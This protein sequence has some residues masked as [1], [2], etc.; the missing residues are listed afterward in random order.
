MCAPGGPGGWPGPGAGVPAGPATR[1]GSGFPPGGPGGPGREPAA[2]PRARPGPA[3][4]PRERVIIAIDLG[5]SGPKVALVRSDGRLLGWEF[6]PV[7]TFLGEGGAAEQRPDDWFGA[8]RT[9]LARLLGRRIVSV[10]TITAVSVTAQWMGTVAIDQQGEPV[11]NAVIWMDSRGAPYAGR[12][13]GGFPEVPGTGYNAFKLR[14][15]LR[16]SGGVPSRTGKDPV[17][18][19]LWLQ[20]ERPD[21]FAAA[22]TF[23]DVPD[24]VNFR[25]TGRAC[26][27]FDT[28]VGLWATDNRDLSQVTYQDEL[29]EMSGLDR[30]RLPEL[31]PT[32][33]V[34]GYLTPTAA[35]ELG[36]G[37]H[38]RHVQVVTATGDTSSAAIG[39]GAVADYDAHLYIGTSSWL[40]CHVPFK[41]T[42]V[43][44]NVTS[45]PSGIPG[46]WWV[47]TEQDTAA[48]AL[49][50]AIDALGLG[51]NGVDPFQELF[52]LAATAP[53]GSGGVVFAPWLNGE[54]TPVDDHNLRGVWF[55][56]DLRTSRAHLARAVL[57][58]VAL[59]TR[60]MLDA[61]ERFVHRARPQGFE[62]LTLVGGGARTPLWCQILAD[63]LGRPIHQAA[64]PMLAN[65][66]GA[67]FAASVA[68]GDLTWDDIPGLVEIAAIYEPYAPS[69]PVYDRSYRTLVDL[70]RRNRRTF[71]TLHT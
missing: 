6:A 59:N 50:W 33:T 9:A 7:R 44:S 71:A 55:G 24:Y 28:A 29:V 27:S 46:R 32:N 3:G 64:D 62:H 22:R 57:E 37:D 23:L 14:R 15:W 26:A 30:A 13:A 35:H 66:R 70:Y 69:K 10:S 52:A 18:H 40:S 67:A 41:R 36:L 21:V 65:V 2:A 42:N 68:L 39:A 43:R 58:G 48:R 49:E 63:V 19:I 60:W 11:G 38:G 4:P 25:L 56:M 61:V 31:V 53:P 34:I 45:L 5:T 51:E 8:I 12:V 47:A 1:P 20:H 16:Y 17:G 54:R